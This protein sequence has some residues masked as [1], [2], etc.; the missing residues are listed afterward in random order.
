MV[1]LH[2]GCGMRDFG[3]TWDHI[4][5][6]K[7]PHIKSHSVTKLPYKDRS[8][9]VIY[10]CHLIAYW[11]TEGIIPVLKEWH[12]VLQPGGILRLSTPDWNV[13]RKISIPLLGPLYGKLPSGMYHKTVYCYDTLHLLLKECGFTGIGLYN[14]KKTRHA[15]FD[16]HSHAVYNG[17]LI[18]LNIQCSV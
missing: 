17:K 14:H 7:A 11:D 10:A 3:P 4:D 8:V 5:A 16:D 12:R 15:H 6:I 13:L 18:S 2:L 9:D 1:K